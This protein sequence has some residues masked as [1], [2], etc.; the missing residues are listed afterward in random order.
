MLLFVVCFAVFVCLLLFVVCVCVCVCVCVFVCVCVRVCACVCMCVC[1]CVRACVRPCVCVC[2]C[3]CVTDMPG[4]TTSYLWGTWAY[5]HDIY[6]QPT[7][8]VICPCL[9]EVALHLHFVGGP[10]AYGMFKG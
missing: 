7:D 10:C 9:K 6:V 3:V 5:I 8:R 1:A 2:V 4:E